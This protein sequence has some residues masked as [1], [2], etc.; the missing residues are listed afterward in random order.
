MNKIVKYD[1]SGSLQQALYYGVPET[2][3]VYSNDVSFTPDIEVPYCLADA[4]AGL[5]A[6]K[7]D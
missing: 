4:S 7:Q 2:F 5:R 6:L 3:Y 1:I